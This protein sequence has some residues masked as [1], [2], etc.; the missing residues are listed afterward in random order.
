MN[1]VSRISSL[2]TTVKFELKGVKGAGWGAH[3]FFDV[4]ISPSLTSSRRV[5]ARPLAGTHYYISYIVNS[6]RFRSAI[7]KVL[8]LADL[9]YLC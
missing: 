8:T 7:A 2:L 1:S 6:S 9:S 3:L 4:D 5:S